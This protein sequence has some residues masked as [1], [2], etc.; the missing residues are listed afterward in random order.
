MYTTGGKERSGM[1][2]TIM[3]SFMDQLTVRSQPGKGTAVRMKKRLS[4]RLGAGGQA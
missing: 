2:F 3:E 4:V 1:G